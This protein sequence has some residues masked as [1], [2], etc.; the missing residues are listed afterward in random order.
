[1]S[2][3]QP[4]RTVPDGL[5]H[6]HATIDAIISPHGQLNILSKVE[7]AKLL[8]SSHSGLYKLFRNCSLAVLNTGNDIDDGKEL[9]ERY[10]T[11]DISIIQQQRGIKLA[12]KGAPTNAFVD[13]RMIK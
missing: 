3:N 9:L 12:V 6:N 4:Y 10:N 7:V 1:M 8:D 13:G 2:I 11:F 5:D